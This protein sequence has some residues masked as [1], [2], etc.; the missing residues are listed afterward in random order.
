MSRRAVAAKSAATET[1]LVTFALFT[2]NQEHYV[3][4]AVNAALAQTYSNLQIIISDDHSTDSTFE[5]ILAAVNQ[6]ITHHTPII[7]RN[8][9]NLGLA[10]HIN[11]VMEV[12]SGELIVMAAG[13]DISFPHRVSTL[14]NHW[15]STGK[16]RG[17]IFS[18]FQTIDSEGKIKKGRWDSESIIR[19]SL[20]SRDINNTLGIA[21]GAS[22]CTQ[23]WTK[24]L[25]E[26]F[27]PLDTRIIH[28]DISIPLRALLIGSVTYLPD[29]LIL[30]RVITGTLSRMSYANYRQRFAKMASYWKG[31]VAN[32]DQYVRDSVVIAAH[33]DVQQS[34]LEWLN[35]LVENQAGIASLNY[36]FFSGRFRDQIRVI[37][38][39]S[40]KIGFIRRLKLLS[41]ALF[42]PLY[43]I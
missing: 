16:E 37:F 20:A 24:D 27:G 34:D 6:Q 4:Y 2:Y 10:A 19:L 8:R 21:V 23:A 1:P 35:L 3:E 14:V 42:P 39:R 11:A 13:D 38:D 18:R 40:V 31:R 12:A 5:K 26:I 29:E 17:S 30:Y 7:R 22:G 28:E 33:K 15:I 25:F 41:L 36:Q 32:Y 43:Q 9:A